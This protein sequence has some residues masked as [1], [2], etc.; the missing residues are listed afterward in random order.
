MIQLH[1]LQSITARPLS[2]EKTLESWLNFLH[3]RL[4]SRWLV[5]GIFMELGRIISTSPT[6]LKNMIS[7]LL[8][9]RITAC[10]GVCGASIEGTQLE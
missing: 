10:A 6:K 5:L 1:N 8:P 3:F 4:E 2:L 7:H 9:L